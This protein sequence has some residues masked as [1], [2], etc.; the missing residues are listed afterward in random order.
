MPQMLPVPTTS[1]N[2]TPTTCTTPT[3]PA[4]SPKTTIPQYP[5]QP[6]QPYIGVNQHPQQTSGISLPPP[7]P[8]LRP[9]HI[10]HR[11][12]TTRAV[13][14]AYADCE[15][16]GERSCY[17]CLRECNGP[18]CS[19]YSP[20][21]GGSGGHKHGGS[22]SSNLYNTHNLYDC[23]RR[24]KVCSWCA[25]EGLTETGQE[26]VRCLDCVRRAPASVPLPTSR[27]VP[28]GGAMPGNGT[29]PNTG[30]GGG[31]GAGPWNFRPS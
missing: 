6:L 30:N 7:A 28:V 11:R 22:Q 3:S 5:P 25:V 9:C 26:V 18:D 31:Y 1:F 19:R 14:D 17:I 8:L 4:I 20:S 15:L 2:H 16:C 24:R 27:P 13:L 10:C 12:P 21:S 29:G 23:Q